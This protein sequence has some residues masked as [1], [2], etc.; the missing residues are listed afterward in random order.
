MKVAPRFSFIIPCLNE[1]ENILACL[2]TIPP[3]ELS[4]I[5]V[6]DGGS[7][8]NT[9]ALIRKAFPHVNI[10]HSEVGRA[11]QMNKGAHYAKGDT[12]IFLHADSLLPSSCMVELE[13]FSQQT[14]KRWG[15]FDIR[16]NDMRAIFRIIE[17]MINIRSAW[18][19]VATGDQGI[20]VKHDLFKKI[21]GFP[22]LPLMEDVALSQSLRQYSTSF[23]IRSPIATSARRWQEHGVIKTIL[24]MWLL[25]FAF[26]LGVNAT[27][28]HRFYYGKKIQKPISKKQVL[29]I[30]SKN[31]EPGK[32]K[33][34]LIPALGEQAAYQLYKDMLKQTL[35]NCLAQPQ[36]TINHQREIW[37]QGV[38]ANAFMQAL[39]EQY[40]VPLQQQVGSGLE[41]TLSHAFYSSSKNYTDIV[42]IGGDCVSI[43][44]TYIEQAFAA[45]KNAQCV[46]GPAEDGGFVLLGFQAQAFQAAL[47]EG[48]HWGS[49]QVFA[50]LKENL[51]KQQL[52][53]HYLE[54]LWDVDEPQDLSLLKEYPWF[55]SILSQV[56]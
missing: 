53:V 1:A 14:L 32:V 37:F 34:R 2:N 54:T 35:D 29:I 8:D 50:Q 41:A 30:F 24:L 12:L 38:E 19:D 15:R 48:V 55:Q 4:E 23:R 49:D 56:D 18:S 17:A 52:S 51:D 10:I 31:P 16:L 45:L 26:M 44:S 46:L 13:K 40:Q 36:N 6:V 47:F 28:L 33:T 9:V 27:L 42:V 25:R 7:T 11:T 43:T 21:N 22:N 20:F 39:S 3:S 5:I